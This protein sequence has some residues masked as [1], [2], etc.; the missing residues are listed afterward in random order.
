MAKRHKKASGG[1][2][3]MAGEDESKG[4]AKDMSYTK[5]SNVEKE[6]K[7]RARGGKIEGDKP[8]A[9]MDRACKRA[10]GGR[11]GSDKSPFSSARSVTSAKG[12]STDNM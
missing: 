7:K 2:T 12:H 10:S 11:V 3:D 8:K 5:D 9:R 1:S 4:S 6:A